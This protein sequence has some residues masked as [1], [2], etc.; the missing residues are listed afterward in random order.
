M[1]DNSH[2][3]PFQ[4]HFRSHGTLLIFLDDY[5]DMLLKQ[6]CSGKKLSG[7]PALPRGES[8][9]QQLKR[10]YHYAGKVRRTRTPADAQRQRG[11]AHSERATVSRQA[12]VENGPGNNPS[13]TTPAWREEEEE[14]DQCP[15]GQLTQPFRCSVRQSIWSQRDKLGTRPEK[16]RGKALTARRG[17][18]TTACCRATKQS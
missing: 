18:N 15:R 3:R 2:A 14:P 8:P 7:W 13:R 17:V 12:A 6:N 11:T 9:K 16:C 4:N 5:K 1:F 10:G